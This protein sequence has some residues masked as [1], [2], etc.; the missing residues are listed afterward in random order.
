MNAR[1]RRLAKGLPVTSRLRAWGAVGPSVSAALAAGLLAYHI[2]R[3]P[4]LQYNA[5][6]G[7]DI[8]VWN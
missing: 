3:D 6:M 8:K 4:D 7:G 1:D 2:A 5:G